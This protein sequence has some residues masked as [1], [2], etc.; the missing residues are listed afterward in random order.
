[1]DS[2]DMDGDGWVD[3]VTGGFYAY[4][5]Y[6]R[7]SRVVLWKNVWPLSRQVSKQTTDVHGKKL[8]VRGGMK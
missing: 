6:D 3:F 5:P 8:Q 7:M 4:P 1:L 2:A